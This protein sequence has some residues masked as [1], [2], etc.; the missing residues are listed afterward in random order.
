MEGYPVN[1]LHSSS[2]VGS[3]NPLPVRSVF[4]PT[5]VDAF[6]RLRVSQP[7]TVFD[8]SSRYNDNSDFHTFTSN[9]GYA[10]FNSN[11]GCAILHVG[12]NQGDR[13]YRETAKIFAYQP[14]KSLLILESFTFNPLT[15]GLRQRVGYF[16]TSNGIYLQAESSNVSF[17]KRSAVSGSILEMVIPQSQWNYDKLDGLGISR[18]TLDITRTQIL[19]IDIEWLGVGTVRT[20][21][22]ID[23]QY[24][25]C[26]RFNHAN[27]PSTVY[28][29]TTLP[30]MTTACLPVRYELEN[31]APLPS[32]QTGRMVVTCSSVISEGGYEIRGK[33]R[34]IGWDILDAPRTIPAKNTLYP[35]LAL[36]L[37]STH[38]DAIVVPREISIINTVAGDIRWAIILRATVTGGTW[39]SAGNDSS[40]EYN[41]TGTN[42][43]TDGIIVR[44]GY[45]TASTNSSPSISLDSAIFRYQLERNSFTQTPTNLVV[46]LASSDINDKVLVSL[47]WE[48]L[49]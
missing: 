30:Y 42:T 41:L 22:I 49:T 20:G 25:L 45:F 38:L 5:Q 9:N 28:N 43:M 32:N 47:D 12:S 48:E 6:G 21:F 14:G 36:R 26:H 24:Y 23:G 40:V 17:V 18:R 15:T 27:E 33:P 19:F 10:T 8:S 34:S 2:F 39:Y 4:A 31:I 46:A 35:I 1:I 11:Q 37:K 3:S 44:Q 16:D 7:L 29:D 13:I